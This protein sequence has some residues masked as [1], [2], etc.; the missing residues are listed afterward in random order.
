MLVARATYGYALGVM[1][2]VAVA[3]CGG[4]TGAGLDD[5]G[6]T[7]SSG[8]SS[9]GSSGGSS[10]SGSGSGSSSGGSSGSSSGGT[11]GCNVGAPITSGANMSDDKQAN[12]AIMGPACPVADPSGNEVY[13]PASQCAVL[14]PGTWYGGHLTMCGVWLDTGVTYLGCSY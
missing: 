13:P 10:G 11:P 1:G 5:G 9:S 14:C 8:G 12:F 2:A 7:S 3:A 4:S 6:T